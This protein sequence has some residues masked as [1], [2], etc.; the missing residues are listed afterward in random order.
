MQQ[1]QAQV[2]LREGK[3]EIHH[4]PPLDLLV[5]LLGE[6]IMVGTIHL[7]LQGGKLPSGLRQLL[8]VEGVDLRQLLCAVRE[9]LLIKPG[10][11]LKFQQ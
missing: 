9:E 7:R 8:G 6:I 3:L 10:K 11:K 5:P 1:D 4:L 2:E